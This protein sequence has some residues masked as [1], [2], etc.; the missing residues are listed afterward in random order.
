[1]SK[2]LCTALHL[3][4]HVLFGSTMVVV[5]NDYLNELQA[6]RDTISTQSDKIETVLG[7]AETACKKLGKFKI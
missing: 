4:Y 6:I 3:I 7:K 1:M 2:K 5:G